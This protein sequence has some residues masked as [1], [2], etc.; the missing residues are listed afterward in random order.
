MFGLPVP[1]VTWLINISYQVNNEVGIRLGDGTV[2]F[3]FVEN[4]IC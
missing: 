4:A 3:S 2:Y 1:A